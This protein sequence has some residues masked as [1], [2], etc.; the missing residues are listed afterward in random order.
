MPW[1]KNSPEA[2]RRFDEIAAVPGARRGVMFG[3]PIYELGGQRYTSLHQD[4]VVLRLSPED[5]DQL[6]SEGGRPFEPIKGRRMKDRVVVPEAI[7]ANA[8]SL[9]AWV[10]RA[11]KHARDQ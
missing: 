11:A 3:C 1:K 4:R 7:A 2:V 6:I 8:R 9:R 5:V 10:R